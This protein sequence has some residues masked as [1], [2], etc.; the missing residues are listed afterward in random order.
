MGPVYLFV[1]VSIGA[2]APAS[3]RVSMQTISYHET[4]AECQ[5]ALIRNEKWID[6]SYVKLRCL[7][8]NTSK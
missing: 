3:G 7:P 5:H 6:K 4:A 8:I 1:L 2:A